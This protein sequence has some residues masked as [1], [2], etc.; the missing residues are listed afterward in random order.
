MK[1][2]FVDLASDIRFPEVSNETLCNIASINEPKPVYISVSVLELLVYTSNMNCE[3]KYIRKTFIRLQ[4][5]QPTI[6]D[7]FLTNVLH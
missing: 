1:L 2:R 3:D 7:R 6:E 4:R 5:R